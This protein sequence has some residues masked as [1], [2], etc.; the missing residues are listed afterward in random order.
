[1]MQGHIEKKFCSGYPIDEFIF[2]YGF[3]CKCV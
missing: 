3:A 1:M 2:T